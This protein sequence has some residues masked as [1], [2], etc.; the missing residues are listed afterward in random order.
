MQREGITNQNHEQP[1]DGLNFRETIGIYTGS[2]SE[3]K[4]DFFSRIKMKVRNLG[5]D[6]QAKS[7][8]QRINRI[9]PGNG[10][11]QR[12]IPEPISEIE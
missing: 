12:K 6:L 3:P 10:V 4:R 7:I 1:G 8:P 2:R 9:P 11:N 5:E